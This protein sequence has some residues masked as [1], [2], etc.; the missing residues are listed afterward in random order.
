MATWA[1]SLWQPGAGLRIRRDQ[2]TASA[3]AVAAEADP[4][5]LRGLPNDD[6]Y[7]YSKRIDNSRLVR[8][9]ENHVKGEWTAIAGACAAAVLIAGMMIAPG[10]TSVMDSIKIQDLKREQAQLHNQQRALE[11][12][13][14]RLIN[15]ARLE[16]LAAAHRLVRPGPGQ[17][18]PLQPRNNH[19]LAMNELKPR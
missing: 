8:Q 18:I 11:V 14:E 13:E 15:A 2:P 3:T 16:E 12:E 19:S 5:A 9:A 4:L 7:F 17:L 1:Q 6:I 10:V